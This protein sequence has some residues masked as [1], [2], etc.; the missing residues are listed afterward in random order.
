[1]LLFFLF[2]HIYEQ[3]ITQSVMNSIS[4]GV[5]QTIVVRFLRIGTTPPLP[6]PQ[7]PATLLFFSPGKTLYFRIIMVWALYFGGTMHLP[8]G[9]TTAIVYLFSYVVILE[10]NIRP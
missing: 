3:S 7:L 2:V 1:V 5:G 9:K 8:F 6:T 10:Y 4:C